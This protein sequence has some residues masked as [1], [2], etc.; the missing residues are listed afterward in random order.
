MFLIVFHY[1][2]NLYLGG[3]G[4]YET[5]MATKHPKK[6]SSKRKD[7]FTKGLI[8]GF[9]EDIN[10]TTAIVTPVTLIPS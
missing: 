5:I 4:I 6:D 1:F 7:A 9:T 3:M 10:N 2:I 8:S